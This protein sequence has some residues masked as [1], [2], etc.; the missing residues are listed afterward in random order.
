MIVGRCQLLY[1]REGGVR[2]RTALLTGKGDGKEGGGVLKVVGTVVKG[3][4]GHAIQLR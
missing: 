4:G 1:G 2:L 3:D